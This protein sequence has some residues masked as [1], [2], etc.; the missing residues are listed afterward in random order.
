LEYGQC[1]APHRC[2]VRRMLGPRR[3]ASYSVERRKKR[4]DL[5][6]AEEERAEADEQLDAVLTKLGFEGW[7]DGK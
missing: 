1:E 6:E 2:S 7:R 5:Q 4:R 3:T